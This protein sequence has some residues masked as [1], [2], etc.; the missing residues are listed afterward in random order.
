MSDWLRLI[1]M[2]FYAPLRGMREVRDR[3]A[4]LPA[5]ACAY[6]SQVAYVFVTQ[7]LVGDKSFITR[8]SGIASILFQA[9]TSML[10]FAVVFV[11]LLALLANLFERRGSFGLVLQQEYAPLASVVFYALIAANLF[12]ILISIFFHFS[13]VQAAYVASSMQSAEPIKSLF[14]LPVEVQKQLDAELSDSAFI[15]GSLFRSVKIGLFTIG[16]FESVRK[17]FRLS[18][19]RSIPVVV[20]SYLAALLLSPIWLLLFTKLI[21]SPLLLLLLFF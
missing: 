6:L 7:W 21:G 17:V 8:P 16:V 13:G 18:I 14:K 3:G 15:A 5:I 10:P 9:A 12:T 4:L 1:P 11:P 20:L 19:L 2:I